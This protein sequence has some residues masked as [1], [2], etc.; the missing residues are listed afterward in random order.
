MKKRFLLLF[1]SVVCLAS[2]AFAARDY[3]LLKKV[4]VPGTGGWDYLTVDEA[5]R[6]IYISHSTQVDVLDADSFALVGTIPNTPGVHGIAI[7]SEFGRGYISA[8]KADAV[9][10]FDLKTLEPMPRIKVGKK[11]D[12]IIYEPLTKR[13]YVMNGDSESITVLNAADG[14]VA[15]TIPLGGGPEF[16]VSDGKGNLYVNLEEQNETLHIDVHAL[17]VKDRWPLA[18]CAT[19]TS[20]SLDREHRRLFVGCRSH[21][22]A[23]LD[24]DSGKVIF[25]APIGDRVDA[26]AWDPETKLVYLSTGDGKVFIFHEDSPDKYSPVEEITTKTGAKTMGYDPKTRRV[27]V[28]TSENGSMQ[29]MVFSANP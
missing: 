27:I 4:A 6:R 1:S 26:G 23:V 19:P 2:L 11:P 24:A 13:V 21:H 28:P 29:V 7:A 8:G 25:T 18:P 16:A 17:K 10:P 9:V 5:A 22:F 14:A 15:G 12:A 3:Q 20:L